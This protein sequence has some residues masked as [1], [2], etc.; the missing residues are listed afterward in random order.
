MPA[1]ILQHGDHHVNQGGVR[2]PEWVVDLE[3][4]R[5]WTDTEEFP[6]EGR[7]DYLMGEV[8]IDM[9]WEQVFT[10]V[11]AKTEFTFVLAGVVK[12]GDLG[13]YLTDGLRLSNVDAD[14]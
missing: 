14:L 6:E 4:F 12:A 3:S 11:Q 2:V 7:I 10:H 1:V 5:R 8:W 9:S 13:L